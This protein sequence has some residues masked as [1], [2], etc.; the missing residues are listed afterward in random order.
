MPVVRRTKK[1]INLTRRGDVGLLG[2]N[3]RRWFRSDTQ[4]LG[5]R[6]DYA[7]PVADPPDPV[8]ELRIE[9]LDDRLADALFNVPGL[10]AN[11]R[12]YLDRR[13]A[14]WQLGFKG[15]Y[16]AVAPDGRPAYLQFFIPH[17]QADL[18]G[19]HWGN[20]FPPFGPDTLLVE[21]AWTP[22]DFR[23]QR[24]M[25]RAL[26][27]MAE[28]ARRNSAD[29]VRFADAYVEI[30]NRGA[31]IGCRQAGFLPFQ[32]R[33][34]SWRFGRHTFRFEDLAEQT[35]DPRHAV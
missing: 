24:V 6:R 11:N 25:A 16:V 18:V 1:M 12:L 9:P 32:R 17:E 10:D 14:M 22:P 34:E 31:D 7:E 21:G 35:A 28:E 13:R 27:L 30:G 33:I 19:R 2:S 5:Y 29:A 23:G 4:S 26:Y 8:L 20:L 3:V 15:G